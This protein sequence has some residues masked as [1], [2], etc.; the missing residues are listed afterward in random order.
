MVPGAGHP[1]EVLVLA[2]KPTPRP[3]SGKLKEHDAAMERFRN[4]DGKI[5]P[6]LWKKAQAEHD[7]ECLAK[8]PPIPVVFPVHD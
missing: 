1:D 5:D 3:L 8:A 4:W 2:V 7:A 6:E